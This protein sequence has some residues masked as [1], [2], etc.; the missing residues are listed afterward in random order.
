MLP[1]V[2]LLLDMPVAVH[3]MEAAVLGVVQHQ[4]KVLVE[5]PLRRLVLFQRILAFQFPS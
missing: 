5:L 4:D 3:R 1:D 2:I